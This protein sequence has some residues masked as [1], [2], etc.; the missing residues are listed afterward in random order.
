LNNKDLNDYCLNGGLFI[1]ISDRCLCVPNYTG[2]K[3]EI[4]IQQNVTAPTPHS[5][6]S[7]SVSTI[8]PGN[9]ELFLFFFYFNN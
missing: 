5:H 8:L 3:C 4:F 9:Y 2:V 6:S 7:P 1:E